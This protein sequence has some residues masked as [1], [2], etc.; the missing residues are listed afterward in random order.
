MNPDGQD[1]ASLR[2]TFMLRL[3]S[4]VSGVHPKSV[5]PVEPS[6]RIKSSAATDEIASNDTPSG[7][8]SEL[9][10]FCDIGL[11]II[12][13]RIASH[14]NADEQIMTRTSLLD[15]DKQQDT[16]SLPHHAK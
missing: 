1:L 13:F 5:G 7:S 14:N 15:Q 8:G 16:Q 6:E 11:A 12:E 2:K 4:D 10:E 9:S 3:S